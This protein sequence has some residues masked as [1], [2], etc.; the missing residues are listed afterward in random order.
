MD[1]RQ[2]FEAL[3]GRARATLADF[4]EDDSLVRHPTEHG[5]RD[6]QEVWAEL[7]KHGLVDSDYSYEGPE[8]GGWVGGEFLTELGR[9]VAALCG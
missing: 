9:S 5:P 7:E 1:A 6:E 4:L 8:D 3:G 2:V